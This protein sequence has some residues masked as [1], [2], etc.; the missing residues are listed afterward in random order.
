MASTPAEYQEQAFPDADPGA[1][2][3]GERRAVAMGRR[4]LLSDP[5]RPAQRFECRIVVQEGTEA[6][7]TTIDERLFIVD[8]SHRAWT[9]EE[10]QAELDG[11][12]AA[13]LTA[14]ENTQR[15]DFEAL[16]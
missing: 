2:E 9:N 5:N 12:K 11:A 16:S 1:L 10:L 13:A 7:P 3:V 8:L 15:L 14:A 6:G 4:M